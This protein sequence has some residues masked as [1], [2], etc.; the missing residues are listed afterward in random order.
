MHATTVAMKG[1]G[2]VITG[3][4]GSGK[5]ALGL[6]LMALGAQLVT[7][8]ITCLT[9]AA[10]EVIARPPDGAPAGIEARGVGLLRADPAGPVPVGLVI[11]MAQEERL[12]LP[13][14]RRVALLGRD[15]PCFHKVARSY[16][17]AAILQ[18][19]KHGRLD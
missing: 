13:P 10:A 7:D 5:S 12:R 1:R 3:P 19:L 8:D 16:F 14:P 18:Y 15:I 9:R 6:S 4:S 2:V 17:P 11:D